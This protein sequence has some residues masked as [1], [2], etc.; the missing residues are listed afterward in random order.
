M[1]YRLYLRMKM[2]GTTVEEK[3]QWVPLY[4]QKESEDVQ[5]KNILE[6]LELDKVEFELS[7]EFL[8]ELK[9]EF[10]EENKESVKVA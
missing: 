8:L 9:K 1:A 2:K 4:M 10:G 3:I 7:G 5:K 6:N